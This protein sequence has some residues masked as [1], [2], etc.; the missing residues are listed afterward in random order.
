MSQTST[1]PP[2][3]RQEDTAPDRRSWPVRRGLLLESGPQRRLALGG[4]VNQ[5]GTAAFLA[6]APLYALRVIGLPLGQVGLG[7]G[8]AGVVGLLAGPPVGHL[9]DRRG[10]RGVF[11]VTLLVQAVSML[12]LLFAHSFTAFMVSMA[13][14]DLAGASGGAAR[15]P[16]IR[17]FGGDEV[18][19]FRS[20]LRSTAFLASTFGALAAG[21]VIQLDS[22]SAYRALIV[23]NALT[24]VGCAV[25]VLRLPELE[26]LPAATGSNRWLALK[27]KPYMAF[28]VLDGILWIQGEVV[29]YALPLWVVLHTQAPRWFT[30]VALAVNTVMVVVL[31]IRTSRGIKGGQV[32]GRATRRAGLAF[33]LGMAVIATAPGLPGWAAA[34]VMTAGVAVHTVGSL[35]HAAGSLELRFRLAPAHAQGQYSG[36]F[37]IGMGLCY[38]VAPGLLG[39]LCLSWGAPGWLAMGGV[40]VAAGLAVPLVVRWAGRSRELSA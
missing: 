23:A 32:A 3:G 24:F 29:T 34:A 2:D 22:G 39:L 6:T 10:P 12:S 9:A 27:D 35:W 31:Q 4:F 33:L 40:F 38:T 11:L 5:L 36:V 37:G 18:P 30:G 19:K 8:V 1:L 20:Y 13:V 14:T 21:A 15:G 7:L 26:P 25:V 28:V 16:M 17:R